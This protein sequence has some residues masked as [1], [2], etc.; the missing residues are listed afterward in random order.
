[1]MPPLALISSTAMVAPHITPSPVMADGPLIADENPTR[2]GCGAWAPAGTTARASITTASTIRMRVSLSE[3]LQFL[4]GPGE[5]AHA[6]CGDLDGVLDLDAAPGMLVVR[7]LHAEH[8]AGLEHRRGGR[9]D[10]GRIVGLEADAVADVV[11]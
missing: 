3:N 1:M 10:G 8:H 7:R 9:V 11:T 5:A 6:A 4:T 2:I